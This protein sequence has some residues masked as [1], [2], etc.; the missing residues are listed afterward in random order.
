M[1]HL[2]EAA[3]HYALGLLEPAE[4]DRVDEHVRT[5]DACAQRLGRAE[6]AVAALAAASQRRSVWRRPAWPV[7]A[8]A[9]FAL[10]SG[11]LLGQNLALQGALSTDG[12]ALDALVAS[13]FAH[14][15]FATPAGTPLAAKVI[16]EQQ[17]RWFQV[18]AER[19]ADW[20]V[21]VVGADGVRR[22]LPARP[23]A[24]GAVSLLFART[25]APVRTIEIED[26][27]GKTIGVL[28]GAGA[29]SPPRG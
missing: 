27:A 24:R 4:R 22:T 20:H 5:C 13:H 23:A 7:A 16:Y 11:L 17:G 21:T 29:A 28:S 26:A 6:S 9:A 8:A 14:A 10:T 1:D 25:D 18:V 3:E 19:P 2:E 15:Q 12:Q